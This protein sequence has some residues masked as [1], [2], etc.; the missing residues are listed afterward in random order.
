MNS[1]S[2]GFKPARTGIRIQN[3]EEVYDS[4]YI[5]LIKYSIVTLTILNPEFRILNSYKIRY[6]Q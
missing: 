3:L 4:R 2:V 6:L 5:Y 1:V